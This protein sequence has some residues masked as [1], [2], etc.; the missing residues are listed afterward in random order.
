MATDVEV[1]GAL[2]VDFTPEEIERD[3]RGHALADLLEEAQRRLGRDLPPDTR[4][5]LEDRL[6][7]RFETELSPTPG[8]RDVLEGLRVQACVAS[9]GTRRRIEAALRVTGLACYFD[10][11]IFSA[12]EVQRGKPAPDLFLHAA[13]ALGVPAQRCLVI[14]DSAAG[15]AAAR[16]A[17]MT[18]FAYSPH[19]A[20]SPDADRTFA[21][22]RALTELLG[23]AWAPPPGAPCD[24]AFGPG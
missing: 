12:D 4:S 19:G 17:G 22:M 21:S 23:P 8:I 10:D 13:R 14:E 2:G 1:L 20:A 11:R 9:S 7:E 18:V 3:F 15:V 16:A 24:P 6:L 5:R